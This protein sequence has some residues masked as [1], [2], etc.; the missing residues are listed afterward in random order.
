MFYSNFILDVAGT[1]HNVLLFG[2]NFVVFLLKLDDSTFD[3][4]TYDDLIS[5]DSAFGDSMYKD[6]FS[7]VDSK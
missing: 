7:V 1:K 2:R 6:S 5:D 3:D 4:W